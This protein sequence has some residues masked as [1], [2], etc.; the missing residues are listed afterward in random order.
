MA[1]EAG[2]SPKAK[3]AGTCAALTTVSGSVI[4]RFR[5]PDVPVTMT[6]PDAAV[7]FAVKVSTLVP[8]VEEGLKDAVTP[9]GSWGA[10]RVTLPV[11]P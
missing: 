7:L 1:R 5:P 11:I 3:S 4:G 9:A 10:A 8:A 6:N 2:A